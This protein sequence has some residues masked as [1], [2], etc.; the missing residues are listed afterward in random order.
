M[1]GTPTGAITP[2][3]YTIMGLFFL[4]AIG[5]SLT[6]RQC[7]VYSTPSA[8]VLLQG[9]MLLFSVVLT[10]PFLGHH[11][12][13]VTDVLIAKPWI[14]LISMAKGLFFWLFMTTSQQLRKHSNS[15]TEFRAPLKIAL[16]AII[17]SFLG[18]A[19]PTHVWIA[20]FVLLFIGAV[21]ALRGHIASAPPVA[22]MLFFVS[23]LL[24]VFFGVSDQVVIPNTNWY[25]HLCFSALGFALCG[26][27]FCPRPVG[28]VKQTFQ[29][30]N[31]FAGLFFVVTEFIILLLL[32]TYIPV[33]MA[34]IAGFLAM[35]FLMLFSSLMWKEGC[36]RNQLVFGGSATLVMMIIVLG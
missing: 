8:T 19:L 27:L 31:L 13:A 32:V 12:L 36:W 7:S 17:N 14:A 3:T 5:R 29:G 10:F 28:W 6:M 11:L 33:T 1:D 15:S 24:G 21:F 9:N 20:I 18:E 26:W 25:T 34:A 2:L 22:K 23:T 4:M 16:V 35:P 30:W